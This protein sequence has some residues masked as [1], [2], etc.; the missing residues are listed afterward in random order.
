MEM[1]KIKRE[2]LMTLEAYHK[3][4]PEMRK[5]AMQVRKIRTV[6]LGEHLTIIF[7]NEFLMRY[8]IQEM[9]RV[10]KIF[11]DEGIIDEIEAYDPLV[12]DGSNFKATMMLE[13]TNEA[14]RKVALGKLLGIEDKVFVEVEG[15]P[16]VYAIADEDLDRSTATKTSSVHFL[17]FELTD[18]MKS[19][20]K[21]G[22][23][24][25]VGCDHKEYPMHVDTVPAATLASLVSD[26][27]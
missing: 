12:P 20:L 13:Y 6:H 22:A 19:A 27:S 26:L 14:E 17:R 23:Q 8:Q 9:L 21:N 5:Q 2:S 1:T 24:L 11:D 25:R 16:R 4:R 18:A 3:A 10:E 7:E 15:Q